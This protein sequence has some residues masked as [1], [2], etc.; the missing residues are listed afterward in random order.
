MKRWT[1]EERNENLELI[2]QI[3]KMQEELDGFG[4]LVA[5]SFS[6]VKHDPKDGPWT[7][8]EEDLYDAVILE[9]DV[10][11]STVDIMPEFDTHTLKALYLLMR[12]GVW[13]QTA[14]EILRVRGVLSNETHPEACEALRRLKRTLVRFQNMKSVVEL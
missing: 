8:R 2:A 4:D 12:D 11:G 1:E 13:M 3:N 10:T 14:I 9:D 5:R 7:E 6:K